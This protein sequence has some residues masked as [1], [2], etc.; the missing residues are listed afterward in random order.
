MAAGIRV[1]WWQVRLGL[2]GLSGDM[3]TLVQ[4]PAPEAA[5]AVAQFQMAAARQAA[6]L[7]PA[8]GGV[9]ALVFT[10][11][12]GTF[13]PVVRAGI[14]AHLQWLGFA[15]D[16]RANADNTAQ[17]SAQTAS[18]PIWIVPADEERRI[19]AHCLPFLEMR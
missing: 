11:G 6:S 8:L 3:R 7:A 2:S 9:D 12:I 4:S 1:D 13:S 19:A 5:E 17:I 14:V 15:L 18:K 10:G 16:E